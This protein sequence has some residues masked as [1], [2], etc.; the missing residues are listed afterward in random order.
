VVSTVLV[1]D[2]DAALLDVLSLSLEEAGY[3]VLTARDGAAGLSAVRA[4]APDLV[5]TDV[6]LPRMDGFTLCRTLRAEGNSVPLIV[7]TSRDDEIDESLGF[8]LGADD[9]VS[10]PFSTRVLLARIASLL[11]RDSLRAR[12]PHQDRPV[13]TGELEILAER[14]E[15]RY[16]G[17]LL[18]LTVSEFRLLEALIRR[19]GVVRSRAQLLEDVRGND[20][21]VDDRLIDTSV[22]RLRRAFSQIDGAFAGIET[23]IGVGYRWIDR[24]G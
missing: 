16:R 1:I 5:L 24:A 22:R 23:V 7:L 13:V 17:Q 15:A 20:S 10:K 12:G 21:V 3:A 2:D 14:F 4:R 8:E 6:N 18:T 19:P 11:R 9:Y